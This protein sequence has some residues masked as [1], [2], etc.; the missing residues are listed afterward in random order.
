MHGSR[1]LV[2]V[3]LLRALDP[4]AELVENLLS[5]VR[6]RETVVALRGL[7]ADECVELGPGRVLTGLVK[8]ILRAS[9]VSA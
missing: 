1:C 3:D 8:R 2:P 4:R 6:W 5:P 9:E 7:G